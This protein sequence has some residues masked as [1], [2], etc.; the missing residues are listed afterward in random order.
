MGT[1][2]TIGSGIFPG[3]SKDC[4]A[5][6]VSHEITPD[7]DGI[8]NP[9]NPAEVAAR[10]DDVSPNV[11]KVTVS[12]RA[13]QLLNDS[14]GDVTTTALLNAAFRP[15]VNP[16]NTP[17]VVR[18]EADLSVTWSRGAAGAGGV[19]L[20]VGFECPGRP[21][22]GVSVGADSSVSGTAATKQTVRCVITPSDP[23]GFL[24]QVNI[25]GTAA[26]SAATGKAQDMSF[27]GTFLV[28]VV[29]VGKELK[30]VSGPAET[31][32]GVAFARP[33]VVN[34]FRNDSEALVAEE[35]VVFS[36]KNEAGAVVQTK[37]E[38]TGLDGNAAANFTAA[39]PGKYTVEA[40]CAGCAGGSPQTFK[41]TVQVVET[42]LEKVPGAESGDRQPG[43]AG[44]K[45][46]LPLRVRVRRTN[47]V[48]VANVP[49]QFSQL[50]GPGPLQFTN[51]NAVTDSSGVA[52]TEV[53]GGPAG[54]YGIRALCPSCTG[55]TAAFSVASAPSGANLSGSSS[56]PDYRT[57]DFTEKLTDRG[58]VAR[59]K[60]RPVH[61]ATPTTCGATL[62]MRD[63]FMNEER[64]SSP[65]GFIIPWC[66]GADLHLVPASDQVTASDAILMDDWKL[67][68][69]FPDPSPYPA[70]NPDF[71][72]F[73]GS[74]TD[75][76]IT[77][78]RPVLFVARAHVRW[79]NRACNTSPREVVAQ[80]LDIGTPSVESQFKENLLPGKRFSLTLPF[81]H[82][83]TLLYTPKDIRR[84]LKIKVIDVIASG[85]PRPSKWVQ[86]IPNT[87]KWE[88][89][90]LKLD[91]ETLRDKTA[92]PSFVEI[93]VDSNCPNTHA[94]IK[95]KP[96]DF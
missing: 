75:F 47:G 9:N 28:S 95:L 45:L 59:S 40:A 52:T 2:L 77:T 14:F 43:K 4:G 81:P 51:P 5:A 26:A 12:G 65:D 30:S 6:G 61:T 11:K 27:K 34:V 1:F 8:T 57:A 49:V 32:A 36:L 7:T 19:S 64:P 91:F 71:V 89:Q 37:T 72:D 13:R 58:Q 76:K 48:L 54:D 3:T 25:N 96:G 69:A 35:P 90:A 93:Y 84:L 50:S 16:Q 73:E 83:N 17:S 15:H 39:E 78:K 20:S 62:Q 38:P 82:T 88:G 10:L 67:Q 68:Q 60:L 86:E 23:F 31:V 33:F 42:H 92:S 18:V 53:I 46:E 55:P 44:T 79:G 80:F 24:T 56:T 21:N 74:A 66:A 29:P 70:F 63:P 85:L 87:E 41:V 22:V 94:F